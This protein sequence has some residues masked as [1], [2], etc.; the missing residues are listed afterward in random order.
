MQ[1][2]DLRIDVCGLGPGNPL[3]ILPIVHQAVDNADILIGGERHLSNF[4][5]E[6]KELVVLKSNLEE[7]IGLCQNR[8]QKKV[9]FIVSGDTGFYSMLAW[10][11]KHFPVEELN[12]IPGISSFQ[13][14]F[15]KLG[16]SYET[17][18]LISLHGREMDVVAEV[19]R[20]DLV[21]CLTDKKMSPHYIAELLC[22]NGLGSCLMH[23]GNQLSYHDEQIFSAKAEELNQKNKEFELCSVI[24]Q[25]KQ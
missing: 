22:V 20:N 21:F 8:G 10:I 5:T 12:V 6:G 11:K 2:K 25:R 19:K 13:Y 9:C 17:A 24:I 3:Y 14:L 7:V 4:K 1:M 18:K 23:I 15:A 16:L